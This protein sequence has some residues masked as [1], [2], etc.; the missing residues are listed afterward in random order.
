[1][2]KRTIA[3]TLFI[4]ADDT[5]WENNIFYLQST[6]GVLAEL[7][8]HGIDERQAQA[9]LD[10][11]E[12]RLI[13]T[14]GYGPPCYR[15]ALEVTCRELLPNLA[16]D[17]MKTLLERI[18]VIVQIV[19]D[20]P[21]VLLDGV[22]ETLEALR[23]RNRLVLVTKGLPEVQRPKLARS[24]L[25]PFFDRIFVVPEKHADTYRQ[26]VAATDS[27]PACTWMVG[28][29]PNS[30]IN[31]AYE[32]GIGAIYIPH[33]DTW[34]AEMTGLTHPDEVVTLERF[35]DLVSYFAPQPR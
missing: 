14:L 27:D 31:P 21:M 30:D 16:E 13:P 3:R 28:N 7:A 15:Q 1:M 5:L 18:H 24:G 32:A 2:Q 8:A 33:S 11:A 23:P 29:S 22:R 25:E 4:D 10:R 6:A 12:Q 20:P 34:T 19:I 17:A 9:H 35:G 26:V